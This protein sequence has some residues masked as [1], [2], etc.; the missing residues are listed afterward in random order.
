MADIKFQQFGPDSTEFTDIVSHAN[1]LKS[2]YA[3]RDSEYEQYEKM[4]LMDWTIQNEDADNLMMT[5]SPTARNKVL[6]SWRLLISQDPKFTFTSTDADQSVVPSIQKFIYYMWKRAEKINGRPI[7]HDILLSNLLYAQSHTA[8]ATMSDYMEFSKDDPRAKRIGKQTPV[9][10]QSWNPRY[11]YPEFDELGLSAYYRETEV[12]KSWVRTKYKTILESLDMTDIVAGSG[13][14]YLRVWYDVNI[15][16][17]WINDTLL[18]CREHGLPLIPVVVTNSDGSGLFS[19]PKDAV[20]P[21]LFGLNRSKLWE[22]ECLYLTTQYSNLFTMAIM[23]TLIFTTDSNNPIKTTTVDGVSRITIAR[24]DSID[25]MQQ[26]GILSPEIQQM[27]QMTSDLISSTTVYDTA[28]GQAGGDA[29]FSQASL[30]SQSA[31]LPLMASQKAGGMAIASVVE[32][33]LILLRDKKAK[34][35]VEGVDFVTSD[36]PEMFDIDCKL[37]TTQQQER[38]QNANTA[39]IMLSNGLS[40]KRWVQTNCVGITN[41]DEMEKEM[42]KEK[43]AASLEDY[44]IQMLIQQMQQKAASVQSTSDAAMQQAQRQA[45]QILANPQALQQ[46]Q[47]PSAQMDMGGSQNIPYGQQLESNLLNQIQQQAMMN[48]MNTSGQSYMP[49]GQGQ[50]MKGGGVAGGMPPEMGGL[51]PGMGMP[52]IPR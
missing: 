43:V 25:V 27:G 36:I 28:F 31:R 32:A 16:A 42:L 19:D 38:L 7:S 50:M 8:I 6:G 47:Q 41:P 9:M 35:D 1:D 48:N 22:R 12:D 26:K 44:K 45:D 46:M 15:N 11:G 4:F 20:E 39:A 49:E 51:M 23:P 18:L 30:L 24:G 10:F 3:E 33:A 40:S 17:I 37:D 5:P 34:F 21:L 13:N 2:A 52:E 14:V 29:N